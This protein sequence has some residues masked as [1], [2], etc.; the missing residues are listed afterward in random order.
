MLSS[1]SMRTTTTTTMYWTPTNWLSAIEWAFGVAV[2][3]AARGL[4]DGAAD[5]AAYVDDVAFGIPAGLPR[6]TIGGPVCPT[7]PRDVFATTAC[8]WQRYRWHRVQATDVAVCVAGCLRYH[9]EGW[10]HPVAR[11][12]AA[13]HRIADAP[14]PSDV[15]GARAD[16]TWNAGD[17]NDGG[18]RLRP[19]LTLAVCLFRC[20]RWWCD[21][22]AGVGYCDCA[23]SSVHHDCGTE[24]SCG[25]GGDDGVAVAAEA[26]AVGPAN[27]RRPP[28]QRNR[29]RWRLH[30]EASVL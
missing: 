27:C 15:C 18:N 24:L 5:A 8:D 19:A 3:D 14:P 7:D 1:T 4:A 22:A 30:L 29:T 20:W 9:S 13:D 16:G 6:A 23:P 2:A 17:K 26:A 25:C 11:Q 12:H 21:V 10:L 28:N